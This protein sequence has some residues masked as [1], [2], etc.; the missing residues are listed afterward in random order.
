MLIIPIAVVDVDASLGWM[1]VPFKM[2]LE[3]VTEIIL[4]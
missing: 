1:S 4:V 3:L 2:R